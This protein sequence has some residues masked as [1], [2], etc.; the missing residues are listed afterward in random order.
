VHA[1]VANVPSRKGV[2]FLTPTHTNQGGLA[3]QS[4]AIAPEA[5]EWPVWIWGVLL[6]ANVAVML[7]VGFLLVR[8]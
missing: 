6:A 2:Q 3:A 1:L 8:T 4:P 7:L 5:F